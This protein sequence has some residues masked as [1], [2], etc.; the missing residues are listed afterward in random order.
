MAMPFTEFHTVKQ[1]NQYFTIWFIMIK[2]QL[3][4]AAFLLSIV[5]VHHQ[6]LYLRENSI[7]LLL[8]NNHE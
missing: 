1:N 6:G 3:Q 7:S 8:K 5:F 2:K 4:R